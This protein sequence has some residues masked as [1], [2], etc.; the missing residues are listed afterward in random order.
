MGKFSKLCA[1]ALHNNWGSESSY[2]IKLGSKIGSNNVFLKASQQRNRKKTKERIC[3]DL[4]LN[5][6]S[7]LEIHSLSANHECLQIWLCYYKF[8]NDLTCLTTFYIVWEKKAKFVLMHATKC[9]IGI[10]LNGIAP[11]ST[12]FLTWRFV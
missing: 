11:R 10:I 12:E 5:H 1:N 4:H 7:I 8:H 2:L 3:I 6:N 9:R